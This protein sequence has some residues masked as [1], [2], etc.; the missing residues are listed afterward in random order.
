M[1]TLALRV[2]WTR[3]VGGT[4]LSGGCSRGRRQLPSHFSHP[5]KE[6]GGLRSAGTVHLSAYIWP[7]QPA[8]VRIVMPFTWH[9]KAPRVTVLVKEVMAAWG[10]MIQP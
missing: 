7:F 1:T 10:F 8:H 9:L 4:Q 3:F 5:E 6:S 2:V